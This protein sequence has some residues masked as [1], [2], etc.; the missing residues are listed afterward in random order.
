[1]SH[2]ML[3]S[4]KA[5]YENA[6]RILSD[7]RNC[8]NRCTPATKYYLA[9]IAQEECAK[10]LLLHLA[11]VNAIPWDSAMQG[12]TRNHACKHLL[13]LILDY[14]SPDDKEF[15]RRVGLEMTE[16]SGFKMPEKML[17]VISILRHKRFGKGAGELKKIWNEAVYEESVDGVIRGI[18]DEQKQGALYVNLCNDGK[19]VTTPETKIVASQAEAECAMAW[20]FIYFLGEIFP[21]GNLD[22][23]FYAKIVARLKEIYSSPEKS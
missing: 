8:D 14:V 4:V 17:D 12:A 22:N 1:M 11:S 23:Y 7:V 2:D 5:C 6:Q 19:V 20:R 16:E 9:I 10:A 3:D 13:C 15:Q 18:R 21:T